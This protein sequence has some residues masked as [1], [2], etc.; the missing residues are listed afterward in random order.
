MGEAKNSALRLSF[1]RRLRLEFHGAKGVTHGR[2][3]T[4]QMAE[5]AVSRQVFMAIL[6]RIQRLWLPPPAPDTG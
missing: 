3:V 1:D 2:Y 5:G 4:V 6:E